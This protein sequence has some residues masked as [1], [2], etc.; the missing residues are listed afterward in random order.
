V[1]LGPLFEC[2][3]VLMYVLSPDMLCTE[4]R[5]YCNGGDT[6]TY[7]ELVIEIYFLP[8]CQNDV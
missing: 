2:Y 7:Q 5:V 1:D 8:H 6:V 4:H 3:T